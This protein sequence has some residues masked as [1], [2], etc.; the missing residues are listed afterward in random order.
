MGVS[1]KL[2]GGCCGSSN[3]QGTTTEAPK[4]VLA[5]TKAQRLARPAQQLPPDGRTGTSH[6]GGSTKS[7]PDA[8][9][10]TSPSGGAPST[11]KSGQAKPATPTVHQTEKDKQKNLDVLR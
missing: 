4:P 9:T 2:T 10:K 3:R 5:A 11:D 6:P 1:I 7:V 8:I